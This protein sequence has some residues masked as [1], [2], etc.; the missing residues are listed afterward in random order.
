MENLRTYTG[1]NV[2]P[3]KAR[4]YANHHQFLII[5]GGT[6]G[7][8]AAAQLKKKLKKP[9]IAIIEP[10][11]VHYYQPMW[12]FN[13]AGVFDKE[14]S[15]KLM[16]DIMPNDVAW[17]KDYVVAFHPE[18]NIVETECG[19]FYSYEFL[20]V[21]PGIQ[22]DWDA[23]PGLA[24]NIGTKG[25][26]SIYAYNQ[27]DY[28]HECIHMLKEGRA[29]FTQPNT[30]FKCGG[31]PQKIMYL[32][33]DSWKNSG[34]LH[35][36]DVTFT[37]AGSVI[38]GVPEIAEALQPVIKRYGIDV[39][40]LHNL[41]EI[42]A[43]EKIAVYDIMKDGKPVDE[44]E[45]EYD[46]LHV[47][48]PMSSPDFI[49]NSPLADSEGWVDVDKHSLQ[50]KKYPNI[51]SLGDAGS[52]PNA[53]TGAAVRKQAPVVTGNLASLQK[54]GKI[55]ENFIYDG[56]G[57]CPLITGYNKLILAEFDYENKMTPSFP[58][59]QAKERRSMYHM[60]KDLLPMIYWQGMLKGRA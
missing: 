19:T 20:V 7:I 13:G 35:D 57:S 6:G 33:S 4:P 54:E 26:C 44:M 23:I 41:K 39:K 59:N 45:I 22:V 31:A 11:D 52:T 48:P 25:I 49:K 21:A 17:I 5:G 2:K 37:S 53:K 29:L 10:S 27:V 50:H 34:A 55:D 9:D 56:Y 38:F 18:Q 28:V 36:I 30:K 1:K 43:D 16:K 42:K 15:K 40:L 51:F 32:S 47:T 3:D 24:E 60:K 58:F 12:T 8:T 46:M 14:K